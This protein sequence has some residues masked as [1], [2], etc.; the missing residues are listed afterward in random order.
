MTGLD[1]LDDEDYPS[2][3]MGQAAELLDVQQAFLRSLD[4][5]GVLHPHRTSGGHRRYSRRQLAQAVRLRTLV[6]A[7]HNLTSAQM[8]LELE[9]Q[10]AAS[11]DARRRADD[12]RD[13]ARR[14]RDH[15]EAER[16]RANT[17]Q[18]RAVRDRDVAQTD[19]RERSEQLRAVRR[20][21]DQARVQI[22]DLTDRLGRSDGRPRQT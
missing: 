18:A 11:D 7:G 21:L 17:D 2:V 13:E 1:Q 4:A 22:T 9:G 19:L 20:E 6:D 16:D 5:A 3:S 8:I 10:V 14:D 15:A 12:A